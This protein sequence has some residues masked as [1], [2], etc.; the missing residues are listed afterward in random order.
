[1]LLNQVSLD[2]ITLNGLL[3]ACLELNNVEIG[4]QLH[5][6]ILKLGFELSCFV[7]SALVDLYG[8]CGLVEDARRIFDKVLCPD[9]VLWNVM[10]SCNALNSLEEEAFRV[11]NLMRLENL[12]GDGF[13]FSSMLNSC[14]T[15]GSCELGR[16]IH[17]LIIKLSFDLDIIVSSGLVD[18]Y[19]KSENIE[20]ARKAFDD[21]AANNVVSWNTMVVA[22]GQLG[23]GKE[24]MKLLKE[25]LREVFT[26]DELTVASILGSCS[27]ASASYE[28]M[29]VHAYVVKMGFH[30]FLS[31]GNA[32]INAYA[33]CGRTASA[34]ECFN[35]VPEPNHVTRTSLVGAYA[36]NSLPKDS[37]EMF[38][39]MLSTGVMPDKIAFLGVLS[40]RSHAGLIKEGFRY[41]SLMIKHYQII[42]HLEHYGCLIDL[43]GRA[44]FLDEAFSVLTSMPIGQRSDI[45]AAFIGACKIHGYLKLAKWA[46]EKLLE[47]EPNIP[48]YYALIS[49][50]YASEEQWHDVARVRKLM[51]DRCDHKVPGC[52]WIELGGAIHTFVSSDKCHPQASEVYCFLGILLGLIRD[53]LH[54]MDENVLNECAP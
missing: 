32:I 40:A 34:L 52:S 49:N 45:L 6:F 1:M 4:G 39:K 36:F 35:S 51:R 38:E 21:M 24:A 48:V 14:A 31:I 13:T 2:P 5:C 43:L 8:K 42:P 47:L 53:E 33:K 11:F 17:G 25:M 30:S 19:A 9:L 7:S 50:M 16:Q 10:L 46:A 26:P 29:Q 37:I 23:D 3:R 22:Y 44:G 15:L 54:A 20:D 27:N 41:F 28:I 18:M 12:I